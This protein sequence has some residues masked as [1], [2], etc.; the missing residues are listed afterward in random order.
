[1]EALGLASSLCRRG[2]G[3]QLVLAGKISLNIVYCFRCLI[4]SLTSHHL[5]LEAI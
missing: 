5:E 2:G 1:M 3:L 4:L